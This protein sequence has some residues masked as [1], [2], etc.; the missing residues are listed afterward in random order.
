MTGVLNLIAILIGYG[1]M[2]V[3]AGV[4][5]AFAFMAVAAWFSMILGR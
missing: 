1:V 4:L 3:V 2:F 5:A